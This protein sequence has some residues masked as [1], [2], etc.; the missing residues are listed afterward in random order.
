MARDRRIVQVFYY[1]QPSGYRP[2]C[3]IRLIKSCFNKQR[4]ESFP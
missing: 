4:V 3:T 1:G 2:L